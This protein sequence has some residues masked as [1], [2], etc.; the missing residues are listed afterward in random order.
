MSHRA[1]FRTTTFA[2]GAAALKQLPEDTGEEICVIGRSNAGK[3][4]A[5][6]C[7]AGQKALARTSKTPGRTQ[8][9]NIFHIDRILFALVSQVQY[10]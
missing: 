10:L 9:F 4:T 1:F 3:S 5:L 6:N 8:Q 2:L 7:L